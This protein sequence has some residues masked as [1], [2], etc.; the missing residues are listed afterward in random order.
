MEYQHII[1]R[2]EGER[3]NILILGGTRYFGIHLV[4]NLINSGHNITIATRGIVKD[5]FEDKVDRIIL[6]RHQKHSLNRELNGRSFDMIYDNIAFCSNDVKNL[7]HTVET[8]RY[9]MTSTVSVYNNFHHNITEDE[10][11]PLTH[12][13][14]WCSENDFSYDEAKRQAESALF[15]KYPHIPSIAVRFPWVIGTDDYTKRLYFYVE[16]VLRGVPMNI[17]NLNSELT[18]INSQEAGEFLAYLLTKDFTKTINASS[19][20]YITIAQI[21]HYS[22][23]ALKYATISRSSDYI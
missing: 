7:L 12:N 18:F 11:D 13:L 10:F 14:S 16:H 3:M 5:H 23:M 19:N 17:D 2:G 15:Q 6:N 8:K 20:G 1:R 9:I 22:Q 4:N 21:L